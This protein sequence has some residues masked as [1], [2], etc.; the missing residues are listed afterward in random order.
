MNNKALVVR[1]SLAL[2]LAVLVGCS[3][4]P[5]EPKQTPTNPVPP[6][7]VTTFS[8][9]VTASPGALTVGGATSSTIT[10]TVVRSDTGTPPPDGTSVTLTTTLGEFGNVGSGLKTVTLQLVGGRAQAVL[11]PGAQ[12]GTATLQAK[13]QIAGGAGTGTTAVA[14]NQAA[15]FFIGSVN[16]SVGSPQGGDQVDVLGGGFVGP[17]RVTFNG[18]AAT[19]LSVSATRIRVIVPSAA[20]A[21][22]TVGVGQSAPVSVGVTINVNQTGTASDNLP[23]AFTYSFGGTID[24]PQ[25]F[26][27]TP[28]TGTN[29]GGTRVTINGTGFS[30]PVQ[31]FFEG[32]SPKVSLEASVVSVS[33]TQIVVLSPPARGFGNVLG[34]TAVD[35][36]VKNLNSGFETTAVGAFR[37]GSKVLI[38]SFGPGELEWNDTTTLITIQ[39]QGFA[40]P[41]AAGIAGVAAH[42]V[43]VSGTEV[44]VQS[45]GVVPTSCTDVTGGVSVVNINTG[46][47]DNTSTHGLNFIYRVPKTAVTSIHPTMGPPAGG[48]P[49]TITGNGLQGAVR[50]QFGDQTASA[51]PGAGGTIV[52]TTPAFSGTPATKTC[53]LGNGTQGTQQTD[54]AVDVKI[55][56]LD[57]T[58]TDTL[59]KAFVYQTATGCTPPPATPPVAS[60]Q[61]GIVGHTATFTD[62]STGN[63][64]TWAWTF[65]DGGT[66]T[67]QNPMHTYAAAGTYVVK[68]TVSNTAGTSAPSTQTVTIM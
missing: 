8:V 27:V 19:V 28:S 33:P 38:T 37:Y 34:N 35:I 49:V 31:V 15:T 23:N 10:V 24:Q 58:C 52:A 22:V 13:V 16:P 6:V 62:T 25:V 56:N 40:S 46:D 18:A 29:D 43:S 12:A 39:G 55:T 4:S 59:P 67:M 41:V 61:F 57:T 45:P 9:S 47:G 30:S 2:A 48:T 68:L 26:S 14:I 32:A 50:V 3:K 21:G 51:S 36:R 66:S 53:T 64:T 7:P 1:I 42:V 63:P 60:F 11:F 44:V 20:A 65:G 17:V 5:T 54:T